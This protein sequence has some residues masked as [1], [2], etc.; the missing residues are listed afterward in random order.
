MSYKITQ[1]LTDIAKTESP[2]AGVIAFNIGLF[3]GEDGYTA[4]LTGSKEYDPDDPDWACN[5]DFTPARK[6]FKLESSAGKDWQV[7]ES[8][9]VNE[10]KGFLLSAAATKSFFATAKAVT[11]GFDDGDLV[12][13]SA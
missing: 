9:I 8:E 3:E 6:Y 5:E 10:A 1:W 4:Y 2:S 13:V 12:K 11:V 7:I